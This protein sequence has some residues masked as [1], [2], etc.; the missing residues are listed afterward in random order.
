MLSPSLLFIIIIIISE[1]LLSTYCE[2]GTGHGALL[3]LFDFILIKPYKLGT[4]IGPILQIRKLKFPTI[5]KLCLL[6]CCKKR[7]S[8]NLNP[9]QLDSRAFT[10]NHCATMP[11]L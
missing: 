5:H 4:I 7:L 3:A 8:L 6:S 9:D 2:L 1:W 11:T 10:S